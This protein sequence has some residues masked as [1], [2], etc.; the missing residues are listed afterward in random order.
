MATTRFTALQSGEID[1][2]VRTATWTLGLDNRWAQAIVKQVGNYGDV[3]D[4]TVAPLGV[5]RSLNRPWNKGGLQYSPPV[6]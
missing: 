6:R 2:L 3:W 4:R 5:P 1:L